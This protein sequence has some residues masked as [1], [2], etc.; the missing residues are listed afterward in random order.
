M[1]IFPKETV[2][3]IAESIGINL[4]DDISNLLIQDTEYRTREIIIEAVKF[5]RHSKRKKL[6][7]RDINSALQTKN[8]QKLYGYHT[9]KEIIKTANLY[10]LQDEEVDLEELVSKPLPPVPC[11]PT[12]TSHWLAIEGVQPRIVQNPTLNDLHDVKSKDVEK[13]VDAKA[14]TVKQVLTK[15][16]QLYYEKITS[17]LF[18]ATYELAI[19]SISNDPGI[20]F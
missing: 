1:S 14:V 4:K 12:F 2:S 3:L 5:A 9:E 13:S 7:P 17:T 8:V 16:L 20:L 11:E 10:Y 15:E 19:E 18:S 6:L